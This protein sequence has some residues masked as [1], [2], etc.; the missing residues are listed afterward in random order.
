MGYEI[1]FYVQPL[2]EVPFQGFLLF[3]FY[4]KILSFCENKRIQRHTC[5]KRRDFL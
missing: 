1:S 3:I 2:L 4:F 5:A